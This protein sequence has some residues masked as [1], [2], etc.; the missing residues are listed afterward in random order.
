MSRKK[1]SI[2]KVCANGIYARWVKDDKFG[3]K[4]EKVR[5]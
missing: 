2:F 1:I 3:A 4:F 5:L